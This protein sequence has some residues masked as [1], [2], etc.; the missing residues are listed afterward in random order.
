MLE[1]GYPTLPSDWYTDAR[2]FRRER[3]AIW[4][5]SW[6]CAG[7]ASQWALAGQWR[8]LDVGGAKFFVVRGPDGCLRAFHNT[9]RHRGSELC[10]ELSGRFAAGRIVCPYHAWTYDLAG[11]L[12]ETPRRVWTPDFDPENLGLYEI[13]LTCWAGFVFVNLAESPPESLADALGSEAE[14]VASWPLAELATVHQEVHEV[15]CNWKVFWE[16]FSECVHCPGVHPDLGRLVPLYR[17]GFTALDDLEATGR[18]ADRSRLAGLRK[19]AVTWS[20]TGTTALPWFE[21]LGADE[22]SAGMTFCTLWP[23]I[24]IIAHV[25]YVRTVQVVPLGPERIRLTISWLIGQETLDAGQVDIEQLTAFGR[26]V[27]LEDAVVC[28]ANQRGLQSPRHATGI[29]MPQEYD[30][31]AFD[32]WVRARL[33]L[34]PLR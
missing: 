9:C 20:G 13:A 11:R 24:F 16:N 15:A 33:G 22:R 4:W 3:E 34:M 28:E 26:Q 2:H 5:R 10:K 14:A 29:L 18:G 8:A 7:R 21:G 12:L 19:G 31:L 6:L 27:V 25:D 1:H 17:E 32:D 30:V 23:G